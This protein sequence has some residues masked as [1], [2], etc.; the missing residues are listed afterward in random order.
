MWAS[1]EVLAATFAANALT[2]GTFVRDTGAKKTKPFRYPDGE[3]DLAL[4]SGGRSSSRSRRRA[5][6]GGKKVFW[7]DPDSDD[8][9]VQPVRPMPSTTLTV[10]ASA[11]AAAGREAGCPRGTDDDNTEQPV[12][13]DDDRDRAGLR[14][15][16]VDSLI[17]RNAV[18]AR[19]AD[20]GGVVRTTTIEVTVSSAA[21]LS[22][23]EAVVTASARGRVRG[24]AIPLQKLD[25]LS[26]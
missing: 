16:S 3:A 4:P 11:A 10:P 14:A 22:P 18:N 9:E 20:H 12:M 17:P 5:V 25:P 13:L 6:V 7:D 24:S 2:I 23:A 15:E 19:A 21:M 1:V 8:D 26:S